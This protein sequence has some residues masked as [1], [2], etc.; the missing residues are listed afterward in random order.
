[1]GQ[2]SNTLAN[3]DGTHVCFCTLIH[4]N[5]N[6]GIISTDKLLSHRCSVSTKQV[7][8]TIDGVGV[9]NVTV[10]NVG[11]AP[12][13]GVGNRCFSVARLLIPKLNSTHDT[14]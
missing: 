2:T 11:V 7:H 5:V 12:A 9:G 10:A 13:L 1:M 8:S 3:T 14:V 4:I 6:R